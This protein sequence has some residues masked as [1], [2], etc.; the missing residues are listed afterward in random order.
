MVVGHQEADIRAA[1]AGAS[2]LFVANPDFADGLSTS[3]KVGLGAIAPE[4]EAALVCLGDMP[5][6]RADH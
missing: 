3:L 2:V 6:L 1:L 4:A 5:L